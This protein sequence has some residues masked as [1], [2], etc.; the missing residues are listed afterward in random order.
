MLESVH[1]L[2]LYY[3]ECEYMRVCTEHWTQIE[4]VWMS[5]ANA[6]CVVAM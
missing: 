6:Y 3:P 5:R 1:A 4:V 2:H